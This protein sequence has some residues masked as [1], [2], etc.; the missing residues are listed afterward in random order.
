MNA[1]V[2]S[3]SYPQQD[4]YAFI[5]DALSDYISCGDTSVMA[6]ELR[7]VIDEMKK[8]DKGTSGFENQMAYTI[9]HTFNALYQEVGALC[10]YILLTQISHCIVLLELL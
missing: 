3:I 7:I 6:H 9:I 10:H 1:L 8:E 2:K 5:H 4:Q